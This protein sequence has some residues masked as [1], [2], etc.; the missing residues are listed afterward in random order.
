MNKLNNTVKVLLISFIAFGLISCK[1][2]EI[3]KDEPDTTGVATAKL[4]YGDKTVDFKAITM[5]Q[6][7]TR[8]DLDVAILMKNG[9]LA[10]VLVDDVNYDDEGTGNGMMLIFADG[11]R[12]GT[13]SLGETEL[14]GDGGVVS[15]NGMLA[16]L[17]ESDFPLSI[18]GG[19]GT[20]TIQ[21]VTQSRIKGTFSAVLT[22]FGGDIVQVESGKFDLPLKRE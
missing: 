21:E 8:P 1:K 10:I 17:D 7:K 4:I 22:S 19:D 14:D 15:G 13:F 11:S 3:E 5:D 9:N 6:Y 12:P 16:I 2:K 18:Y 20:A